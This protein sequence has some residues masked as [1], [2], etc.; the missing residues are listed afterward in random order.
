MAPFAN[1]GKDEGTGKE[2][3]GKDIGPAELFNMI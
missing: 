2:G 3:Q 1:R